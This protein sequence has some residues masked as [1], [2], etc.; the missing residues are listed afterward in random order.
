MRARPGADRY[1][2]RGGDGAAARRVLRAAAM[3]PR[4][5][6]HGLAAVVTAAVGAIARRNAEARTTASPAHSLHG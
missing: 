6:P 3:R 4:L 2:R 1:T 5:M